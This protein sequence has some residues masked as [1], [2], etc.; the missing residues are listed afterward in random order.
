MQPPATKQTFFDIFL[1]KTNGNNST[2]VPEK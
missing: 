1:A 2:F